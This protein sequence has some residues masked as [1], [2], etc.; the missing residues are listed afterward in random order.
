MKRLFCCQLVLFAFM[1]SQPA[2]G[3]GAEFKSCSEHRRRVSNLKAAEVSCDKARWVA[4]RFDEKVMEEGA[5]PGEAP[6]PVGHFRCR[7]HQT[8]YETY[9]IRCR[10][11]PGEV[12]RFAWGV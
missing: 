8:G 2:L 5:W 12:V 6:M 3:E 1:L 9:R 7:S 11:D 10:R 4:R